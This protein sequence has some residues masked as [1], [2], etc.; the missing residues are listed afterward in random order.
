MPTRNTPGST[1]RHAGFSLIEL[2][3]TVVIVAILA[4][5]AV[6]TY[7]SQIRKSRRTEARNAVLDLAGREER[8]YSTNNA[9]SSKPS[10]LGYST[11]TTDTWTTVG[12]IGSGYYTIV[13]AVANNASTYIITA[14]TAGI[15]TSDAQ[16]ATF[17]V[18]QTGA[19]SATGSGTNATKDCW[20]N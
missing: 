15:Q 11:V 14:T 4:S 5:I 1:P 9:Y 19:Q 12:T 10:D 2:M 18:D 7:T 13:A 8:F 6:P 16:C 20:G 3:T 17:V